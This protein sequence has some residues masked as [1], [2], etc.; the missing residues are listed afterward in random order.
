MASNVPV[1]KQIAWLS[2]IPQLAVLGIIIYAYHLTGWGDPFLLGLL[3]FY[4]LSLLLRNLVAK[5]QRL[6]MRLVKQ[7][8]FTEA[9]PF[10]EKNVSYFSNNNRV[11]KYRFLTLLSSSKMTYKEMGL[12]NIA[13]CY[14]QTGDGL[15]AKEYYERVLKAFPENGLA[16]AGL[17]MLKSTAPKA[18]A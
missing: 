2:I 18:P 10:F 8:K 13:F 3:T 15:K 14:S 11:D 17:N 4:V 6:G 16:I 7:Q 9:I 12:C 1:I 5:N